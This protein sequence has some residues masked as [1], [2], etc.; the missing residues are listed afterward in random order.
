M[1]KT[2]KVADNDL[3]TLIK[4]SAGGKYCLIFRG[5]LALELQIRQ[6]PTYE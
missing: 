2:S 4:G 1:G 3:V 5:L 6:R